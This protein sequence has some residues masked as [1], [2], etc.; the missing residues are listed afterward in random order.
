MKQ[1]SHKG[2]KFRLVST[3]N[4]KDVIELRKVFQRNKFENGSEKL[5]IKEVKLLT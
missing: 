2:N 4:R 3:I 1:N 5:K